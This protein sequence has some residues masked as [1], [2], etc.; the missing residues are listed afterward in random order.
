MREPDVIVIGAGVAG[1]YAARRLGELGLAVVVLEARDRVG[2]RVR[3]AVD[4]AL[5]VP[6][7]L[8]AEFVHGRP[9]V[10]LDLLHEAGTTTIDTVYDAWIAEGGRLHP[11]AGLW[12]SANAILA[13][14]ERF[15]ADV[16]VETVL[17][18]AA[19]DPELRAVVPYARRMV[20][21]FDAADPALASARAIASEW[22]GEAGLESGESRPLGSYLVLLRVLQNALEVHG[23]AVRLRTTARSIAWRRGQVTVRA[24]GPS[25][26]AEFVARAAIVTLPAAVLRAPPDAA[27]AVGFDPELGERK[28]A[29]L[30]AILTGPVIKLVLRFSNAFWEERDGGRYR[31]AAFFQTPDSAFPSFWTLRPLRLPVLIAWAGGPRAEL[32]RDASETELIERALRSL[33]ELF[34]NGHA[35]EQLVAAHVHDWQRDPYA[36]G[37]Y[38]YLAVGGGGAREILAE[39]LEDALF[40]AGEATAPDGEGGTVAGA[41]LSAE[42]AA[43]AVHAALT[44]R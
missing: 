6:L 25:G 32:L 30:R 16:S 27:G 31:D 8:G 42:K 43:H 11:A 21:G 23:A 26:P 22:A 44:A 17:A 37:A 41:L 13:R 1:L 10:T 24:D 39:P 36:R 9:R 5:P 34:T 14:S 7:E 15:A 18:D 29:A 19:A 33:R 28:T 2:G 3:Q 4:P 40:F 35:D 12:E 38:T 20:E